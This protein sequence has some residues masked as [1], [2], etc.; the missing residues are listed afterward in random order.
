MVR[1]D[2]GLLSGR[3]NLRRVWRQWGKDGVEQ[4]AF[5]FGTRVPFGACCQLRGNPPVA[6]RLGWV[7]VVRLRTVDGVD[8][9]VHTPVSRSAKVNGGRVYPSVNGLRRVSCPQAGVP[10]GRGGP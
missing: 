10:G 4:F 9:N 1:G 7:S 3:G 5:G 6:V 2:A 8:G